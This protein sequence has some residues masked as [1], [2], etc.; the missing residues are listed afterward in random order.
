MFV[1]CAIFNFI[2]PGKYLPYMGFRLPAA[3]RQLPGPRFPVH[4]DIELQSEPY[5]PLQEHT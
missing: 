1:V 2:P 5:Q 3:Q 4:Q